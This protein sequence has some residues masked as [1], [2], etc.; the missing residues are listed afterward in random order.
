MP[1]FPEGIVLHSTIAYTDSCDLCK[2]NNLACN[3]SQ[4]V[5]L[6]NGNCLCMWRVNGVDMKS[7]LVPCSDCVQSCIGVFKKFDVGKTEPAM[8]QGLCLR[9][10]DTNTF[11]SLTPLTS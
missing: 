2:Y 9:K 7:E 4:D 11:G 6:M 10:K 8:Q 5:E 1:F 3:K